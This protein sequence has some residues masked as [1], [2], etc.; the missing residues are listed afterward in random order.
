MDKQ[1]TMTTPTDV[2]FP[3]PINILESLLENIEPYVPGD[4]QTDQ[5]GHLYK[6]YLAYNGFL[7][8]LT[9]GFDT[10][11]TKVLPLQL[12]SRVIAVGDTYIYFEG[13]T[14][15][16]PMLSLSG[17]Q[18]LPMY[19]IIARR[20]NLDYFGA[21]Y[22]DLVQVDQNEEEIARQSRVFLG[23]IPI[24]IGSNFDH[25]SEL[26]DVGKLAKGECPS[27][28]GGYFIA[29]GTDKVILFHEKLS[30]MKPLMYNGKKPGE[31]VC[32]MTN[33]TIY[34]SSV[35]WVIKTK[36]NLLRLKLTSL[37]KDNMVNLLS[38]FAALGMQD[39]TEI[40]NF[41]LSFTQERWADKVRGKLNATLVEYLD[42]GDPIVHIANASNMT[43][44]QYSI[45]KKKIVDMLQRDLFP[46]IKPVEEENTRRLAMLAQMAIRILEHAA[47]FRKLDSRDDWSNKRLDPAAESLKQL[48]QIAF[49]MMM[50]EFEKEISGKG[51]T[52]LVSI[53]QKFKPA[54]ITKAFTTSLTSNNFGIKGLYQK[55]IVE[56]LKNTNLLDVFS[57]LTR[58][59]VTGQDRPHSTAPRMVQPTACG[60]ICPAETQEREGCGIVKNIALTSVLTIYDPDTDVLILD[61][62]EEDVKLTKTEY[63]TSKCWFNG[64]FYG[65]V[66]GK[67]LREKLVNARRGCQGED[68]E[69]C[70]IL[71]EQ[72]SVVLD[73]DDTLHITT[74][75]SRLSRPLLIFNRETK[76][77]VI[78]EKN[79]WNEPF[80]VLL[81][82][83]A[84]EYLDAFEQNVH[85]V[86]AE[87]IWAVE[88]LQNILNDAYDA[89][90]KSYARLSVAQE[91]T[92][93]PDK[94]SAL[95]TEEDF[96]DII[97]GITEEVDI[98]IANKEVNFAME[99][100]ITAMKRLN[101]THCEYDP[102]AIW[103]YAASAIPLPNHSVAP[104]ITYQCLS[105]ETLVLTPDGYKEIGF[106]KDGDK[107]VTID[108]KTYHRF[109]TR[110]KNHFIIDPK[111]HNK[112]LYEITT[113]NGRKIQATGDHPFLT[114]N[115]WIRVNELDVNR[116]HLLMS[117]G[118]DIS[119]DTITGITLVKSRLVADFETEAETHSFITEDGF[120]SHNCKM[121]TQSVGIYHSQQRYRF[122]TSIKRLAF[123]T[124]SVFETQSSR[125]MGFLD[126]PTGT[127]ATIAL[128]S[129]AWNQED[130]FIINRAALDFG[131]FRYIKEFSKSVTE[132]KEGDIEEIIT[133]PPV[134]PGEPKERYNNLDKDGII[135]IG[136]FINPHDAI[137]GR[138][139]RNIITGQEDNASIYAGIGEYGIVDEVLITKSKEE[140]KIVTVKIRN[141]RI[142]QRGD[143]FALR[144]SQKGTLGIILDPEDMPRSANGLI[145]DIIMNPLAFPSRM[146]AGTLIE[147]LGSKVGVLTGNRFNTTAFRPVNLNEV[148]NT[149]SMIGYHRQGDEIFYSGIT[150]KPMKG[151]VFTGV[152]YI[153][154]LK[155]D[156]EDK[157]QARAKG[158]VV[159]TTRQ[160][161]Q[162]RILEGGQRFGEM[163]TW[164]MMS[165]GAASVLK[166][167]L[168]DSSD[169][170][171]IV[172]CTTCGTIAVTNHVDQKYEC[173]ICGDKGNF[174]RGT[175]PHVMNLMNQY[176]SGINSGVRYR[177]QE[178]V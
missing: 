69:R 102:Q 153:Q 15:E 156:V 113:I 130:S 78:A 117:I 24:P 11:V 22:A 27:D 148:M 84:V 58:V 62:I 60:F 74:T 66:P 61:F 112:K 171:Q 124:R 39:P 82:E 88:D 48:F 110:I 157:I 21:Y 25:L 98:E 140:K 115:G 142:P 170:S 133:F 111:E 87:S 159:P 149:L 10:W 116:H 14:L 16:K 18:A 77:L 83:G 53:Y 73:R 173:R 96:K 44:E 164:A 121:G 122:P 30:A 145:P 127:E 104:R 109:V 123:P 89:L 136:S 169:A 50:D 9:D 76:N 20:R 166:E 64:I 141:V 97:G 168:C 152:T 161:V 5:H 150:G 54:I 34:G 51:H 29:R 38:V 59:R 155:H 176:L 43:K 139:R 41:I 35:V 135:K 56:Q 23:M 92:E 120:I 134:R 79:L 119:H 90:I 105:F 6:K 8:F 19:P 107:V 26:D 68:Q 147:I 3:P 132:K 47:G 163:E 167:R 174:A 37:S 52:T 93:L 126:L 175:V 45:Q 108:P 70:R 36:N 177:F 138:V 57:H 75:S 1:E 13:G 143:K 72:M 63:N 137:I 101:Y 99:Q 28:P 49:N 33:E 42:L 80:D 125:E 114:D 95:I 131:R 128:I 46:Q 160:P 100:V 91:T 86:I 103:G 162:G 158:N 165:H 172:Y 67:D 12:R 55:N 154:K 85:A 32:S 106:L 65:W 31:I 4:I 2:S 94:I 144:P 151:Y 71:P 118:D 178:V 7:K 129:A 81:L 40:T 17:Q 146:T